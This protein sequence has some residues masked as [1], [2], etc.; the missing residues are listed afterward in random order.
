M[1]EE[2]N[3]LVK[4]IEQ[5]FVDHLWNF[6][7]PISDIDF[8]LVILSQKIIELRN[9]LDNINNIDLSISQLMSYMEKIFSIPLLKEKEWVKKNNRNN[10]VYN[11]YCRLS[12]LRKL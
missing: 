11:I 1:E 6:A 7:P 3:N 8:K 9:N 2:L 5:Y 4:L 12:N 10:L